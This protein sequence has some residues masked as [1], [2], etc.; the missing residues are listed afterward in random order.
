[1]SRSDKEII[2]EIRARRA[3]LTV[4]ME[5][6]VALAKLGPVKK[7]A[8]AVGVDLPDEAEVVAAVSDYRKRCESLVPKA[9]VYDPSSTD[10]DHVGGLI[11][12]WRILHALTAEDAKVILGQ[13]PD[14]ALE[15]EH[16][17]RGDTRLLSEAGLFVL[18]GFIRQG[19]PVAWSIDQTT[20]KR[21]II[22]YPDAKAVMQTPTG[23]F[24]LVQHVSGR[25]PTPEHLA[26]TA[27]VHIEKEKP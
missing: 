5:A 14:A 16:D 3:Y 27:T 17:T 24:V 25:S 6:E 21:K 11:E 13:Q 9:P 8:A 20:G 12:G 1:M 10:P 4:V 23:S 7:E 26:S 2:D 15:E 19:Q 18:G 22:P